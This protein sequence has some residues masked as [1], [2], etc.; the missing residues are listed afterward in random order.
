M[1]KISAEY[2]FKVTP[3]KGGYRYAVKPVPYGRSLGIKIGFFVF[4][5]TGI[6]ILSLT[7]ILGVL[8]IGFIIVGLLTYAITKGIL[9]LINNK[10]RQASDFYID[11]DILE[12]RGHQYERH[13]ISSLF[14]KHPR[15]GVYDYGHGGSGFIVAG[16]SV[17]GV[18]AASMMTSAIQLN[19]EL[20]A[21]FYKSIHANQYGLFILFGERQIKLTGGLTENSAK[22]LIDKIIENHSINQKAQLQHAQLY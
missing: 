3:E 15:N 4:V 19:R 16:S 22:L 5:F 8:P 12:L 9:W 10:I 2:S 18:L 17:S 1:K 13:H 20:S 14:I 11:Q 21:S 7:D 6:P